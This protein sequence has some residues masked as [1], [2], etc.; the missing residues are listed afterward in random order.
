M[1][2]LSIVGKFVLATAEFLKIRVGVAAGALFPCFTL[3]GGV[4]PDM[5]KIRPQIYQE[6]H[7]ACAQKA[8]A[9]GFG[10][11]S[12]GRT[13]VKVVVNALFKKCAP[14]RGPRHAEGAGGGNMVKGAGKCRNLQA[15]ETGSGQE[16]QKSVRQVR[17][18]GKMVQCHHRDDPSGGLFSRARFTP[19]SEPIC[20]QHNSGGLRSP[21]SKMCFRRNQS[22]A[23]RI[24]GVFRFTS[25]RAFSP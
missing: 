25:G 11:G 9:N 5:P 4:F 14:E 16:A 8:G 1:T 7:R 20:S 24:R 21:P 17:Q 13:A 23:N 19:P 3:R 15:I 6:T 22:L 18:P 2:K 10:G 12:K